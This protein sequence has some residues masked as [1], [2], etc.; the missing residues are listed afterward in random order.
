[1]PG[2]RPARCTAELARRS[3]FCTLRGK[4][5]TDQTVSL[6]D[7]RF[8]N[9]APFVLLGGVNVLESRDFAL[10]VAGALRRGLHAAG[11]SLRVQGLF[12]QGQP[13]LDPL[14][15][16]TGPR[17]GPV[18]SGRGEIDVRG[19]GDHRRAH[20]G[21]GGARRPGVRYHSAAGLSGAPDRPGGGHGGDRRDHQYQEAPV[22]QPLADGQRGG[23]VRRVRQHPRPAVRARQQFWLRQPGGG[24]AGFRR[25]EAGLRQR[26]AD[27]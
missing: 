2:A 18:H 27:L 25:D 23:K 9:A 16:W 21:A 13:L 6:G 3:F 15:P 8:D 17:G 24:Y 20:P 26:P 4:A 10:R 1:M 5:M 11:H 7:I 12:R 14:L 22:S 19:A